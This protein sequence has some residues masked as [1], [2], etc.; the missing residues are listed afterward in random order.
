LASSFTDDAERIRRA[1]EVFLAG[2]EGPVDGGRQ[3]RVQEV[4]EHQGRLVLKLAGVDT[5]DEAER[6]RGCDVC[7]PRSCRLPV[8]DG[9]YPMADVVGCRVEELRTGGPVGTVEGWLET[10]GQILLEVRSPKGEEILV[11]FARSICR[12]IDLQEKLIRVELPEGLQELN[13]R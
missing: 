3:Y 8:A 6:L 11:P 1:G 7:V 10:G 2:S 13:R 4:W 5:I 12:E 9:S